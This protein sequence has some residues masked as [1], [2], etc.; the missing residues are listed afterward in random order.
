MSETRKCI[1]HV[2]KQYKKKVGLIIHSKEENK[3]FKDDNGIEAQ[4]NRYIK[5]QYKSLKYYLIH[6][7]IKLYKFRDSIDFEDLSVL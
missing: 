3:H 1:I 5:R 7:S 4:E 6:V 2:Y